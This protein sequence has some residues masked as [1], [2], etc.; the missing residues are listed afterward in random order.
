VEISVVFSLLL[1][2]DGV[3]TSVSIR[4]DTPEGSGGCAGWSEDKDDKTS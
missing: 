2:Y 3:R 1:P 4:S